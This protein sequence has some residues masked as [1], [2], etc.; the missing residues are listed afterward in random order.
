MG[1]SYEEDHLLRT[2]RNGTQAPQDMVARLKSDLSPLVDT[3]DRQLI[4]KALPPA[5]AELIGRVRRRVNI[6]RREKKAQKPSRM[7]L[8]LGTGAMVL[9]TALLAVFASQPTKLDHNIASVDQQQLPLTDHVQLAMTGEGKISGTR[10][11]PRIE[12]SAGEL[13]VEVT[14]NQGI[15]LQIT[16]PEGLIA[17]VGTQFTVNRSS[18]GTTVDVVE[19][20]VRVVC[21]GTEQVF[22]TA[23]QDQLCK[24]TTA[25][26]LLGR[27]RAMRRLGDFGYANEIDAAIA[28]KPQEAH[29]SELLHL[30]VGLRVHQGDEQ[31]ALETAKQYLSVP[32]RPRE[33]DMLHTAADLAYRLGQCDGLR[34][35]VVEHPITAKAD[36]FAKCVQQP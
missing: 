26:G 20:K 6:Q 29:L 12:W 7:P 27:A 31:G 30:R 3:L 19:G 1:E 28:M 9:A 21:E 2:F 25:A 34:L 8:I 35:L 16:T 13:Q 23:S 32:G 17:V 22:V 36:Q 10:Q 14:P 24:P 5:E 33:A 18:L 15:D 11:A 4:A